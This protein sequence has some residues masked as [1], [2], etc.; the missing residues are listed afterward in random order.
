MMLPLFVMFAAADPPAAGRLVEGNPSSAVRVV[1][2]EDLQC[3]DCA[4]FREMLDKQLLPRF[5]GKVAFEHRDFPLP[6]HNW[7]RKAAIA[8]RFFE[9]TSATLAVKYRQETMATMK[10]IT[11]ENFNETLAAFARKNG[12]DAAKAIAALTDTALEAA[13]EKDYK[14]GVARGV[15]RTPT[16]LVDGEPFI[17]RFTYEEIATALEKLIK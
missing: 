3:S 9:R 2:F 1:I 11:A 4:N 14:D 10:S 16:V 7:A 15:G 5:G 17:E 6:K 8:S 13:V 12:A